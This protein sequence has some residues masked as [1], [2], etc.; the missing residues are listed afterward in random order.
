M[1]VQLTIVDRPSVW[2]PWYP[3]IHDTAPHLYPLRTAYF[4]LV[5]QVLVAIDVIET[6][7]DF[8]GEPEV[9]RDIARG[10]RE[11]ISAGDLPAALFKELRDAWN[12][13]QDAMRRRSKHAARW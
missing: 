11:L 9:C 3:P 10:L 1:A 13:F 2:P 7:D 4:R 6:A 5:I 12:N 8:S